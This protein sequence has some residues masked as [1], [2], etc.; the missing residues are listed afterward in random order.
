MVEILPMKVGRTLL[1]IGHVPQVT[2]VLDT[3][4]PIY[5]VLN[6]IEKLKVAPQ[7]LTVATK[8]ELAAKPMAGEA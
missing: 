3:K 8:M 7:A 2:T 6:M 5:W 1:Y 4:S